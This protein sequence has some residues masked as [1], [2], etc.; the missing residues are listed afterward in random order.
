MLHKSKFLKS[1]FHSFQFP[2]SFPPRFFS[3]TSSLAYQTTESGIFLKRQKRKPDRFGIIKC[4]S[5]ERLLDLFQT[6]KFTLTLNE[7]ILIC[8]QITQLAPI[9]VLKSIY[10]LSEIL[11]K[12]QLQISD[13]NLID[14]DPLVGSLMFSLKALNCYSIMENWIHLLDLVMADCFDPEADEVLKAM[15]G[16]DGLEGYLT[17]DWQR[18]LFSSAFL[19]IEML[20]V[21][22]L[23]QMKYNMENLGDVCR[24][25]IKNEQVNSEVFEE[26]E[27]QL[28]K[29]INGERKMLENEENNFTL[30]EMIN[31]S[32]FFA[33]AD[34]HSPNLFTFTNNLLLSEIK[35]PAPKNE[36]SFFR[37]SEI[38]NLMYFWQFYKQKEISFELDDEIKK[39][40]FK[41]SLDPDIFYN[42]EELISMHQGIHLL[43]IN[44]EKLLLLTKHFE[45]KLLKI[46]TSSISQL[47]LSHIEKYFKL[48]AEMEFENDYN[49]LPNEVYRFFDDLCSQIFERFHYVSVLEFFLMLEKN[50]ILNRFPSFFSVLPKFIEKYSFQYDFEDIC[51]F[52]LLFISN[53]S[54]LHEEKSGEFYNALNNLKEFIKFVALRRGFK[55][56]LDSNFHKLLSAI[57]LAH[58]FDGGDG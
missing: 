33:I 34:Y 50:A 7:N 21:E 5:I 17:E 3:S 16:C 30:N 56:D 58:F 9:N 48:R 39:W 22:G 53:V 52:Y 25:M 24:I 49:Q 27:Y 10:G 51:Y 55:M 44:D 41:K 43:D 23:K 20:V 38:A 31:F 35:K 6:P 8:Y 57:D 13:V 4:A 18:Q 26:I 37:G 40:A 36:T 46:D 11:P 42:I 15:Q 32:Y 54:L 29:Y 28:I 19:K 47:N 2:R 45:N 14:E 1:L 12:I